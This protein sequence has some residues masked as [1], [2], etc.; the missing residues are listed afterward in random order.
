[1]DFSGTDS[2]NLGFALAALKLDATALAE[3][4]PRG[5]GDVIRAA[6]DAASSDE[7]R[8]A[9]TAEVERR[10]TSGGT[11]AGIDESWLAE[12]L[13]DESTETAE[14]VA[15]SLP[16]KSCRALVQALEKSGRRIQPRRGAP[17]A[18]RGLRGEIEPL[19][20]E[21]FKARAFPDISG[22]LGSDDPAARWLFKASGEE[23]VAVARE[24]GL[25]VVV[26]A[27]SRIGRDDLAKL[28]QGLPAGDSVRLV[29]GVVEANETLKPEE[30]RE[31]QRVYLKILK[32]AGIS[33]EL[34]NDA[35]LAFLG[36]GLLARE[37]ERTRAAI[38]VRLPAALG[39]RLLD[40]SA[41]G[42]VPEKETCDRYAQDLPKWLAELKAK[43]IAKS[44]EGGPSS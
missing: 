3:R 28:C 6:I 40:L 42:A 34:F 7:G 15:A 17:G 12:A 26:R 11:F 44:Y 41:P 22:G 13:L 2:R 4:A 37:G 35:G 27:F 10:R 16:E 23:I 30:L 1:M 25:R 19:L 8:A 14:A 38:A 29:S 5:A 31:A 43:D 18:G 33:R 24:L 20:V 9:L 32:A 39:R 21:R 36:A